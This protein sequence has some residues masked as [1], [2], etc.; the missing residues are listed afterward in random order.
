VET[1]VLVGRLRE[2]HLVGLLGDSLSVRHNRVGLLQRD[3][4]VILLQI[5]EANLEVKLTSSRNDVLSGLFEDAL[6]HGIGLG[7]TLETFDEFRQIGR[8]LSLDGKRTTGETENFMT[9]MLC[10]SLK[11]VIV[12]PLTR[13]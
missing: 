4:G 1:V 6:H 2:T 9:R 10:A 12:P 8:V 11:V 3:A 5:L 13:Y 7:E